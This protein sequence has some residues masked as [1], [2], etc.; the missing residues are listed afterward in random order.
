MHSIPMRGRVDLTLGKTIVLLSYLDYIVQIHP[1]IAWQ[2]MQR[3]V[4]LA[5]PRPKS[6]KFSGLLRVAIRVSMQQR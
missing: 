4:A 6:V 1:F 2:L 3:L 5:K